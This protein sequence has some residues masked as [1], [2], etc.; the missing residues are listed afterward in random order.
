MDGRMGGRH[1]R[2]LS[3]SYLR[4]SK[5]RGCPGSLSLPRVMWDRGVAQAMARGWRPSCVRTKSVGGSRVKSSHKGSATGG[6]DGCKQ[7]RTRMFWGTKGQNASKASALSTVP[8]LS[9]PHSPFSSWVESPPPPPA[10]ASAS[11]GT[12]L[13]LGHLCGCC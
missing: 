6:M 5:L 8:K 4:S 7:L 11:A 3:F 12:A 10:V 2:G 1:P 9:S 13:G